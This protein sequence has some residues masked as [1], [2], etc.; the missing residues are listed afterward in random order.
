MK[1]KLS[2][3][4]VLIFVLGIF[5]VPTA[6]ALGESWV[7][8][9][10]MPTDT[11][12]YLE[13]PQ[14]VATDGADNLYV[15]D[16]ENNRVLK[17]A[18]DGSLDTSW[19]GGDGIIGTGAEGNTPEQFNHPCGLVCDSAGNLY[20]AD[21]GNHRI[22][23]YTPEGVLD[24]SWSSNGIVGGTFG[25]GPDQ[26]QYPIGVA[27]DSSNNLW[28]AD[29]ENHRIKR[30][31]PNGT[32]DTSWGTNGSFGEYGSNPGQF[33]SP[34]GIAID[35]RFVYIVNTNSHSVSI[36]VINGNV[37]DIRYELNDFWFPMGLAVNDSNL[38]VA[39]TDNNRIK[40]FV[41]S[42][43]N[44]GIYDVSLDTSWGGGDGIIGSEGQGD[45]Q[46]R[47][48]SGVALDSLGNLYTADR[49]NHRIKRYQ[50]N[51]NLDTSWC[52]DGV[53]SGRGDQETQ[54]YR[55]RGMIFDADGNVYIADSSNHR[56]KRYTPDGNLDTSWGGG[57]GIIGSEG[58]GLNQ[59]Y[60]PR[61]LAYDPAGF[62]YVADSNNYR[63]KRYNLDGTLDTSWGTGGVMG[64][65][66]TPGDYTF[67]EPSG[68]AVDADRN[69]YVSDSQ[70][71]RIHRYTPA[72]ILDTSWGTNGK[73]GNPGSGVDEMYEPK[74]MTFDASGRLYVAEFE[75][76][77]IKRHNPDGTVD[78]T[79]GSGGVIGSTESSVP[80][81]FNTPYDIAVDD[82]G[83]VYVADRDN[84]RVQRFTEDGDLDTSWFTNGCWQFGSLETME[85][86]YMK[87]RGVAFYEGRL[88][89]TWEDRVGI[90]YDLEGGLKLSDLT[91]HGQ[92]ISG[93]DPETLEYTMVVSKGATEVTI[94]ATPFYR[95]S[96]VSGT[97]TRALTGNSTVLNITVTADN[98]D[99]QDYTVN[100]MKS[101]EDVG[102]SDL[103]LDGST[104]SGFSE[105]TTSYTVTAPY[106]RK[107]V[108][109]GAMGN[110]YASEIV[111]TG[112]VEL[113]GDTTA[114]SVI[115]KAVDGSAKVYTLTVKKGGMDST[116]LSAAI[117]GVSFGSSGITLDITEDGKTVNLRI[118]LKDGTQVDY[119]I[120]LYAQCGGTNPTP[121][122]TQT[123]EPEENVPDTGDETITDSETQDSTKQDEQSVDDTQVRGDDVPLHT[124]TDL[125]AWWWIII[126]VLVLG[127]VGA[128]L[129]IVILKRK[130]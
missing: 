85:S 88:Y 115:A 21:T 80:G 90:L 105:S 64:G 4:L 89:V 73:I 11:E 58:N 113:T 57:D 40:R 46:F 50:D 56:I 69:L 37:L 98:G 44:P 99:T 124:E 61:G 42:E 10:S 117:D 8:L 20:V 12:V 94:G 1:K 71:C 70:T 82:Y 53:K 66:Q 107:F 25:N 91:V 87:P 96:S 30:Y 127:L 109:I 112:I 101:G 47:L 68:V 33:K 59:F 125:F 76:Q 65:A 78:T 119:P 19:G 63:I 72:G 54:F 121:Q 51:G 32:L 45:E 126:G 95:F 55:P 62:F 52:T 15:S 39:D 43:P 116:W 106:G 75:G 60:Y 23:R 48:V 92:T 83:N 26:F 118:T 100:V 7:A 24:T 111:G 36:F 29:T 81:Q 14:N 114:F 122:P 28:I 31:L 35:S 38:Y 9:E 102:L 13:E 67:V 22:K 128:S 3:I 27:V 84:N 49:D 6:S 2:L 41:I 79:F 123:S 93:F 103:T 18:S 108:Q 5:Y 17:Y 74:L 129:W 120:M 34:T 86:P 16:T 77:R 97:G 130:N 104:V 110:S